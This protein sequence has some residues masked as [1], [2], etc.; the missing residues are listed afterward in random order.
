MQPILNHHLHGLPMTTS[1]PRQA[2]AHIM[3]LILFLPAGIDTAKE[4]VVRV[5]DTEF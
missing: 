3:I 4:K 5:N 1:L 2:L